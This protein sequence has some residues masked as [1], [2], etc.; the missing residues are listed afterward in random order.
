MTIDGGTNYGSIELGGDN[1]AFI[2]FKEPLNEDFNGRI[3]YNDAN[4]FIIGGNTGIP[5]KLAYGGVGTANVKL[6]T[7]DTGIDVTGNATFAD[8][9][10]AIFGAGSDLQIY[11]DGSHSY[12]VDNGTGNLYA[13]ADNYLVIR[14]NDGSKTSAWFNT[15][16]EVEL[17]YNDSLKFATT[18]AGVEITGNASFADNGKALFGNADDFQI[19]HDGSDTYFNQAGTGELRFGTSGSFDMQYFDGA[20]FR[21]TDNFELQFGSG[22][23]F[24][25]D[26]SSSLTAMVFNDNQTTKDFRFQQAGTDKIVFSFDNWEFQDDVKASFGT[27][28]DLSI[29]HNATNSL[30]ENTTGDLL[31]NNSTGSGFVKVDCNLDSENPG[32][33]C[34]I[35]NNVDISSSTGIKSII[36]TADVELNRGNWTVTSSRIT[37]GSGQDGIYYIAIDVRFDSAVIRVAPILLIKRNGTNITQY[38]ATGYIRNSSGHNNASLHQEVICS[39]VNGDYIEFQFSNDGLAGAASTVSDYGY[40]IRLIRLPMTYSGEV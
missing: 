26:Y 38:A 1:G 36:N 25:M 28:S 32:V 29:E 11:H 23:D 18:S 17:R 9:G 35:A 16:A 10:K 12:I 24:D 37:C 27:G 15:D 40:G 5:V 31:I 21:L 13:Q 4:G 39:L 8:N 7:T 6:T 20:G 3:I 2:D 19:Y 22:N 14:K 30:I 33:I 34:G